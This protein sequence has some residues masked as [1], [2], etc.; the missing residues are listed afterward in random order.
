METLFKKGVEWLDFLRPVL[1]K[2]TA[3]SGQA[4][5]IY[6]NYLVETDNTM[7]LVGPLLDGVDSFLSSKIGYYAHIANEYLTK[8]SDY[9]KEFKRAVQEGNDFVRDVAFKVQEYTDLL[10]GG[11]FIA[12]L[13]TAGVECSEETCVRLEPRAG[14]LQETSMP[15]RYPMLYLTNM[16]LSGHTEHLIPGK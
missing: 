15:F 9:A 6:D 1:T 4:L 16:L 11:K 3:A 12:D 5:N 8:L 14:V 10:G 13:P 7:K 2:M